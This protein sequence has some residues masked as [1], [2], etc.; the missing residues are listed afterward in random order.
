ML[1]YR[2]KLMLKFNEIFFDFIVRYYN[3]FV[4]CV[5]KIDFDDFNI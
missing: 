1:L 5:I 4:V 3:E 2:N